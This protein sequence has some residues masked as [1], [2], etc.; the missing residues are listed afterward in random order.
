MFG[1]MRT[2]GDAKKQ[3]YKELTTYQEELGKDWY[4]VLTETG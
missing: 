3:V 4:S 2:F 1:I